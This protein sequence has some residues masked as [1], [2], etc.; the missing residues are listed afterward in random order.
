[1][2]WEQLQER[3][4]ELRGPAGDLLEEVVAGL[5][6]ATGS[7]RAVEGR[8]WFLSRLEVGGFIGIGH[9]PVPIELE[10]RP[11]LTIVTARNG[12][13]KSS[14]A[15]ALRHLL[16]GAPIREAVDADLGVLWNNL[17][18]A[19]RHVRGVF[20]EQ[21]TGAEVALLDGGQG[22]RQV[23]E[24]GE[25][26]PIPAAWTQATTMFEPVLI[27]SE[28]AVAM[29]DDAEVNDAWVKAL[30]FEV[31]QAAFAASTRI[32]DGLKPVATELR[33]ARKELWTES[34]AQVR[35]LLPAET[36]LGSWDAEPMRDLAADFR[37]R[38]RS[39]TLPEVSADLPG[40]LTELSELVGGLART[41]ATASGRHLQLAELYRL[42]LGQEGAD[43]DPCPLCGSTDRDWRRHVRERAEIVAEA[44]EQRALRDRFAELRAALLTALP[45]KVQEA[46]R[47]ELAALAGEVDQR[48]EAA[49]RRVVGWDLDALSGTDIQLV[50]HEVDA[51][52]GRHRDLVAATERQVG[53]QA[54]DPRV[55]ADRLDRFL[56]V[57]DANHG[58]WRRHKAATELSGWLRERIREAR[59]LRSGELGQAAIE[60][61]TRLCP[62]GGAVLERYL[63]GGGVSKQQRMDARVRLG[64]EAGGSELLS[65]GQRNALCLAAFLPRTLR[66]ENP[67]RFLVLDDPV[68]AFDGERVAYLAEVLA[69]VAEHHQ[70]VVFTHD[71]RFP[72]ELRSMGH[73]FTR[74]ALDR[75]PD[76]TVSAER[77]ST[78][79]GALLD[80]ACKI[81]E[82]RRKDDLDDRALAVAS[83]SLCRQAVDE[84]IS[85]TYARLRVGRPEPGLADE[86]EG[87]TVKERVRDLNAALRTN[88]LGE[89]RVDKA[90]LRALNEGSHF[91]PPDS[92]DRDQRI[93]W[94]NQVRAVVAALD[95]AGPAG[96]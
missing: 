54:D 72:R 56:R 42:A 57:W 78:P 10:S 91:D 15:L 67:F 51:A 33:R 6:P 53:D 76:S 23:R 58:L 83:L 41:R 26:E 82:V 44:D 66:D 24:G 25:S 68:Q 50:R 63:P 28:V 29:R 47:P 35:A 89:I 55:L 90:L 61:F 81:A 36:R 38:P 30:A 59:D 49:H 92:A 93:A 18:S 87:R 14:L 31:L 27:Y 96:R 71:E 12:V 7:D 2:T 64:T 84:G 94:V 39:T 20:R 65:T 40:I 88:G 74:I 19:S 11:G 1:L 80:D 37:A 52:A 3:G 4:D 45:N 86:L 79:A 62:D 77:V 43:P 34:D 17:H 73:A 46:V 5:R 85:A 16:A 48:W 70:V 21:E 95:A 8:A 13:G 69:G 75:S 60:L 9:P 32:Q 22:P